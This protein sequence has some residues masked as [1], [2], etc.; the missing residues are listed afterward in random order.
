MVTGQDIHTALLQPEAVLLLVVGEL[1]RSGV[2][3]VRLDET[4]DVVLDRFARSDVESLPIASAD[5]DT[6]V[7]AL[8]SRQAV[9][10]R[11]QEELD[12]QAG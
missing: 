8:V 1:V 4:L 10:R 12:R 11:Y 2:R 7:L 9:M 3:P 5:D 6:R